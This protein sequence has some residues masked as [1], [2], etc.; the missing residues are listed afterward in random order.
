MYRVVHSRAQSD[1]IGDCAS[2]CVSTVPPRIATVEST[3]IPGNCPVKE[4]T[5]PA[6]VAIVL[7]LGIEHD[8]CRVKAAAAWIEIHQSRPDC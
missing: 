4:N 8:T 6:C 7:L 5:N 3:L 1:E 2:A